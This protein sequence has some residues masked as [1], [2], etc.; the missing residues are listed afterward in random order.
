M[1]HD[2][3]ERGVLS[4]NTQPAILQRDSGVTFPEGN[5][6]AL[7]KF[8]FGEFAQ[9][10]D[11]LK[12]HSD[13][14]WG[15]VPC[16]LYVKFRPVAEIKLAYTKMQLAN[17][18]VFRP[19]VKIFVEKDYAQVFLNADAKALTSKM[20]KLQRLGYANLATGFGN[21]QFMGNYLM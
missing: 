19:V 3:P 15:M 14:E 12:A 5:F 1:N 20:P 6:F 2:E 11:S 7:G 16:G 18:Q 8:L 17:S 13:P 4:L 10:R 9:L 21:I